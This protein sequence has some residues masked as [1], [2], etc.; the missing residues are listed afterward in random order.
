M[1][2]VLRCVPRPLERAGSAWSHQDSG[3]RVGGTEVLTLQPVAEAAV[4][5]QSATARLCSRLQLHAAKCILFPACACHAWPFWGQ[6]SAGQ[7]HV[8]L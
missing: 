7:A 2:T 4:P 3:W 5:A 1:W 6:P 8:S